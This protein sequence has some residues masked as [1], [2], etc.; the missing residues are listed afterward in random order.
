MNNGE[1]DW[2]VY[3]LI[4]A[5]HG[6][7]ADWLAAKSGLD[8]QIVEASVKRLE[9]NLLVQQKGGRIEALSINESLIRCQIRYD[10]LLPFT[11]ENGVIKEKKRQ[12]P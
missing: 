3:H 6:L 2:R 11:I 12:G 8:R 9:H 1:I 5:G 4:V 7:S 10:T